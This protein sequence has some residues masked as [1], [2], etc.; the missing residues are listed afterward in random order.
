MNIGAAVDMPRMQATLARWANAP[1]HLLQILRDWQEVD[2]WVSP[3]AMSQIAQALGLA[4]GDVQAVVAFYAFLH[5]R[6]MGRYR[7]LFSDN[8]TDRM[9]GSQALMQI[10]RAHV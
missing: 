5:E 3:Q 4:I 1:V 8:I 9:A 2:G 6:P 7:V 10:G